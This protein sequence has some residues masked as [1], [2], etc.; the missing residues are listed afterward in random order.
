MSL[1]KHLAESNSI[2]TDSSPSPSPSTSSNV[3]NSTEPTSISTQSLSTVK[4]NTAGERKPPPKTKWPYDAT[5][6]LDDIP[7][8][9]FALDEF[10]QSRMVESEDYC[11]EM[12]P[13]K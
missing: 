1:N 13:K 6:A 11:H 9:A 5:N 8:V 2:M 4:E 3:D 7:G 10:L 12:D